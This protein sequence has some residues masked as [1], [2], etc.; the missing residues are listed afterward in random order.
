MVLLLICRVPCSVLGAKS[1]WPARLG[2][3]KGLLIELEIKQMI[4]SQ[5]DE[6]HF[7]SMHKCVVRVCSVQVAV[8]GAFIGKKRMSRLALSSGSSQS[9]GGDNPVIK[10]LKITIIYKGIKQCSGMK[11]NRTVFSSWCSD[12]HITADCGSREGQLT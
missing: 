12:G 5:C 11:N 10:Q 6:C 4:I 2:P 7:T 9:S 8:L 3:V 1:T